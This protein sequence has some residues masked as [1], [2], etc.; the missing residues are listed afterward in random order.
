MGLNRIKQATY[1]GKLPHLRDKTALVRQHDMSGWLL[2]QFDDPRTGHG[3]GWY[4]FQAS[5][6][7]VE[8]DPAPEAADA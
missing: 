1:V 6:F 4:A 5:D 3:F 2:A 8:P 7:R